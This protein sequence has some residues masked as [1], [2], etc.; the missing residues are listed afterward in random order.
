[1]DI[2]IIDRLFAFP[3]SHVNYSIVFAYNK[4]YVLFDN[5]DFYDS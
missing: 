4:I 3:K 2:F 5:M 1:L